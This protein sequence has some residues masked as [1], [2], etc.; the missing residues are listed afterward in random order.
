MPGEQEDID[1]PESH[2]V[3]EGCDQAVSE[4]QQVTGGM[5]WQPW[6]ELPTLLRNARAVFVVGNGRSGFVMRMAAMRLMHVGLTVYVVGETTTPAIAADDL[7]IA[8]SGSG[9]TNGVVYAARQAAGS[10]AAVVAVTANSGSELAKLAKVVLAVPAPEKTNHD[11]ARG[12]RQYAGT[13]FE[14]VTLFAFEGV[15]NTL[16]QQS[17]IDAAA[18]YRRHANLG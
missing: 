4:I 5:D 11:E 1:M 9:S 16:W 3:R 13:L 14:Q 10:G 6:E 12:S 17:H 18:M 8:A 7:L 2:S 15:F